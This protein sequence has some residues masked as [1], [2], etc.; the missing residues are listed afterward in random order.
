ME[1]FNNNRSIIK[2]VRGNN[3]SKVIITSNIYDI[4]NKEN[5]AQQEK[6]EETLLENIKTKKYRF[7]REEIL[8][9][10][11]IN[12]MLIL[13]AKK[14]ASKII[15]EAIENAQ[16]EVIRMKIAGKVQGHNEGYEEGQE[17]ALLEIESKKD[18]LISGAMKFYENAQKEAKEYIAAKE[19]EIKEMIFNTVSKV[20]KRQ[21]NNEQILIDIIDD[22]LRNIR[23]KLPVIIKCN[24]VNYKFLNEEIKKLK[25]SAGILGD[26]H[27]VVDKNVQS[28]EFILERN[29]GI[30]Q[31]SI[32]ENLKIIREIIFGEGG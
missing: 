6:K 12:E 23:D 3:S 25:D 30:I 11:K 21:L 22:S 1:S 16:V 19:I 32:E 15:K 29:G 18:E 17:K 27:V 24:E 14:E 13:R 8:K 31:Y 20:I 10:K 9:F 4:Y 7:R 5:N 28:G 2:N 26:F